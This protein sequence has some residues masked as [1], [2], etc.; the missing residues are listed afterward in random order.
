MCYSTWVWATSLFQRGV[1]RRNK[2]RCLCSTGGYGGAGS[3]PMK[4]YGRPPYGAGN[5]SC[6]SCPGNHNLHI[7][8]SGLIFSLY[9]LRYMLLCY[10]VQVLEW[11]F[12]GV[13]ECLSW[14]GTRGKVS[15][16][17]SNMV[18]CQ[19]YTPGPAGGCLLV[20]LDIENNY[21]LYYYRFCWITVYIGLYKN[22]FNTGS[23]C[24][25]IQS[26]NL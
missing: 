15:V 17:L 21:H 24:I 3:K 14:Q 18:F 1:E 23:V 8:I 12:P 22:T 4:G 26:L 25:Q 10:K 9:S 20:L 6:L 2:M 7:Y 5:W 19:L 16:L 11:E 13:G